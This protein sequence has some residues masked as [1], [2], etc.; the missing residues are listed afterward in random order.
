MSVC[1]AAL[2]ASI[3]MS[4]AFVDVVPPD[5][6]ADSHIY[7]MFDS[8]IKAGDAS[9]LGDNSK[10]YVIRPNDRREESVWLPIETTAI[11]KGFDDA[12]KMGARE[13]F[14]DVEVNLGMVRGWVRVVD[15]GVVD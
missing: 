9:L 2:L 3:G 14:N 13:Y 5:H 7:M 6:P 1:Y 12:W 4:T 11:T 15:V 8:G 10:L